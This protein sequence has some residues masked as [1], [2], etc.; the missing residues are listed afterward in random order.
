MRK[1]YRCRHSTKTCRM[2][3]PEKLGY[4]PRWKERDLARL[5]EW[6]ANKRRI[7]KE[8]WHGEG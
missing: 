4:T 3:N 1:V 8:Q 2:C 6:D 5:R 7:E